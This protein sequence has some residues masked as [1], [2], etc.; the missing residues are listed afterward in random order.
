MR[1]LPI[2]IN[3]DGLFE[4]GPFPG[5]AYSDP[6]W[7]AYLMVASGMVREGTFGDVVRLITERNTFLLTTLAYSE[8]QAKR[9]VEFALAINGWPW[10][11]KSL[12][13]QAKV[14]RHDYI[15][16]G[17]TIVDIDWML[18]GGVASLSH[19]ELTLVTLG[20]P[21]ITDSVVPL[22]VSP[23]G[24]P[25]NSDCVLRQY[26]D[27]EMSLSKIMAEYNKK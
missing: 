25:D 23:S 4:V 5:R 14:N 18:R 13:D 17:A 8:D 21:N 7:I 9:L 15:G 3:T 22:V 24:S 20:V 10:N 11:E 2:S 12:A 27:S 1:H 16:A 6:V 19:I 26:L